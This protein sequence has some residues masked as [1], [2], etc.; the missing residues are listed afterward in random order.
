[1]LLAAYLIKSLPLGVV[2][3]LVAVYTAV[4]LLRSAAA[5]CHQDRE[6]Q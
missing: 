4:M 5:E 3:W 2:R 1:V 6:R